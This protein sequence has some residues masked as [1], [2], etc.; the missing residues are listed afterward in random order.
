[1]T[2][3]EASLEPPTSPSVQHP[4][5]L[6]FSSESETDGNDEAQEATAVPPIV[7]QPNGVIDL[8]MAARDLCKQFAPARTK[9]RQLDPP[10]NW[11][12]SVPK[13]ESWYRLS[14]E[15]QQEEKKKW[16]SL[17]R[18]EKEEFK[19][20]VPGMKQ[21]EQD[22]ATTRATA[23]VSR[24]TRSSQDNRRRLQ[25][26]Q[27]EP[28]GVFPTG[29][30]GNEEERSALATTLARKPRSKKGKKRGGATN[31]MSQYNRDVRVAER[32][33]M[34]AVGEYAAMI[35]PQFTVTKHTPRHRVCLLLT[36]EID[37]GKNG[38]PRQKT[39]EVKRAKT[40]I[41]VVGNGASDELKKNSVL[42]IVTAAM[43][44]PGEYS[45][46]AFMHNDEQDVTEKLR[47]YHAVQ[48]D[49]TARPAVG[50]L[51]FQE[52]ERNVSV[53]AV[54]AIHPSPSS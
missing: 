16:T 17:T 49:S 53:D 50:A 25:G 40:Q 34:K 2:P 54:T 28:E 20:R 8:S 22:R 38:R 1:M 19:A 5:Q 12:T 41:I 27:E 3:P 18:V 4:T 51:S 23:P 46:K 11:R 29:M 31:V 15:L 39:T 6:H 35:H 44:N 10:P 36:N 45:V 33:L 9:S 24:R 14:K 26:T 48:G 37:Y 52:T 32:N 30:A 21:K 47:S 42:K 43:K 7:L 13:V